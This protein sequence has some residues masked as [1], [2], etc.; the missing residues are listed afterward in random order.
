MPKR[1][2]KGKSGKKGKNGRG[3]KGST[4]PAVVV[5]VQ[6]TRGRGAAGGKS[7]GNPV[8]NAG[9][10]DASMRFTFTVD[11][12][13]ANQS[14][15]LK[16]GPSLSQYPN[17]ADGILKSF[18]EYKISNLQ[19][20]FIS[21]ASSTS[22]GAFAIEI[23]TARKSTGVESRLISFPV[24]KQ[25]TRSFPAKAIRGLLWISTKDDQFNFLFKGNGSDVVAGQLKF[26]FSI[27]LQGPK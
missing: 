21:F 15:I 26:S 6:P 3:K 4:K 16:F 5:N 25:F 22:S 8:P 9:K 2:K 12:V 13:K 11:D 27:D 1:G 10:G 7:G 18:H 14:G 23:D 19:V 17:F 24:T 20:Q